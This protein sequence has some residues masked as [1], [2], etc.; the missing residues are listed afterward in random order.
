MKN[1]Q[2]NSLTESFDWTL[3]VS[4]VGHV[5]GDVAN[6]GCDEG[7]GKPETLMLKTEVHHPSP[8]LS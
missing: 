2:L 4:V 1:G 3:T 7:S 8:P 5:I 6:G